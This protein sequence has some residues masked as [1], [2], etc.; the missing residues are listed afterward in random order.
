[1]R[2]V[3]QNN[4]RITTTVDEAFSDLDALMDKAA[5][6]VKLA[7][8]ISSKLAQTASTSAAASLGADDDSSEM[9]TFRSYLIELG[10]DSPVTK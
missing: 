7:E 10:V 1:M 5:E 4:A 2:N 8:S 6:M 9:A 3:E